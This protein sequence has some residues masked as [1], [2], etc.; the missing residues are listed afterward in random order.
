ML[1]TEAE[2]QRL[3]KEVKEIAFDSGA[4]LVGIVPSSSIDSFQSH[5][6]GWTIKQ[7]TKKTTDIMADTRAVIVIGYHVWDDILETALRKGD[8][9]VYPGTLQLPVITQKI[10]QFLSSKGYKTAPRPYRISYKRLAQLAGFGTFGKNALII[11]PR[12][13]PWI[14]F[15]TVLTNADLAPDKPFEQD[16]CGDCDNCVQACPVAALVPYKVDDSKCL[17]G[18]HLS[19]TDLAKY[20]EV[21]RKFEP[22]LTAGAHL[23]CRECQRACKYGNEEHST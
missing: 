1:V 4:S 8:G 5:W 9:W 13:G 16:L 22:S 3:A 6:V 11:N 18:I 17:I 10:E 23:M 19:G 15:S 20:A 21:L 12:F 2:P 14:R 7:Y